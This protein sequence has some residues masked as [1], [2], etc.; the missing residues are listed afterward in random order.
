MITINISKKL[1]GADYL[2]LGPTERLL[3]RR[4]G[5]TPPGTRFGK[6]CF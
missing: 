3:A 5:S 2:G 4:V 1:E 6:L